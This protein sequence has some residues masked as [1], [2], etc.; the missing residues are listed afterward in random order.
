[1]KSLFKISNIPAKSLVWVAVFLLGIVLFALLRL[2]FLIIYNNLTADS[3]FLLIAESFFIGFRFDAIIMSVIILPLLLIS[4]LPFLDLKNKLIQNIFISILTPLFSII[5]FMGLADIN[6]FDN[7]G[8]HL[9]FWAVEYLS[10][11]DMFFYTVVNTDGFWPVFLFW[12]FISV[13]LFFI[14]RKIF[15]VVAQFG[16]SASRTLKISLFIFSI[17]LF[18]FLIRGRTGIKPLDWGEAFFSK[19]QFIN[20][21]CLNPVYTLSHSLYEE[22]KDNRDI[23][24]STA[25]F[26]FY[27]INDAFHTVQYLLGIIVDKKSSKLSLKRQTVSSNENNFI[28]NIVIV[29]MESWTASRIGVLGGEQGLSPA[30]DSMSKHGLLF[31]NFYANG[32][33]TNRGVPAILCSFPSLP[34]RSIMRRYSA[35]FPFKSIADILSDFNYNSIY[36]YGGDIE[37]DNIRGF[38]IANGFNTFYDENN[39]ESSDYFS[40][41][42]VPD[43]IF[44]EK[45]SNEIKTFKRPFLLSMLTLSYHDPFLVPIKNLKIYDDSNIENKRRN[46]FYYTDWAI[47]QFIE[48]VKKQPVFDSTIF[49][50]TSDHCDKQS[51]KYPLSP[52]TFRIPLLIY[53]PGLFGDSSRL[54]TTTGSQVDILPTLLGLLDI[55]TT[56]NSWGRDL[57]SLKPD[58]SGFAIITEGEKLGLI[59]GSSFLFHQVNIYKKLYDLNDT[60][61][62][63]NDLYDLFPDKAKSMEHKL[64]SYIQLANYLSRGRKEISK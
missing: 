51:P 34:G 4:H 39:F 35:D 1:M 17:V 8:S 48:N 46:C 25:R 56:H 30:F 28:P 13:L 42:G 63:E 44:F 16:D 53:T 5:T 61:Y 2:L 7:F 18:G 40:K 43:H 47:G 54:I 6:F 9:N 32:V 14:I 59:E 22:S 57:L 52:E 36:A 12:I 31:N 11:P 62:L 55:E 64:N 26:S 19:N 20:Q 10:D 3:S 50:F 23:S 41:W 49:I 38:L 29:I 45:M 27:N 21:L 15:R 60:A 37:F 33:R 58:D 24:G